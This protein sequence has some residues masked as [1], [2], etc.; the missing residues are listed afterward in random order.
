MKSKARSFSKGKYNPKRHEKMR[1][2]DIEY[3]NEALL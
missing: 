3:A 1:H 2:R